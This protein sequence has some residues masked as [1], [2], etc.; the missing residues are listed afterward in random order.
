[1]MMFKMMW[2]ISCFVSIAFCILRILCLLCI[3][4]IFFHFFFWKL[5]GWSCG[6]KIHL[7]LTVCHAP[8]APNL[9]DLM[10]DDVRWS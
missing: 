5:S 6:S 9:W 1:M 3:T 8:G 2:V 4:K 7:N 10:A